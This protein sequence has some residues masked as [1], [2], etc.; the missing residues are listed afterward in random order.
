MFDSLFGFVVRLTVATILAL[1]PYAAAQGQ[2]S[3]AVVTTTLWNSPAAKATIE[4]PSQFRLSTDALKARAT[5]KQDLPGGYVLKVSTGE[6]FDA[7][8]LK[9]PFTYQY[10]EVVSAVDNTVIPANS[11]QFASRATAMAMRDTL[12]ALFPSNRFILVEHR[13][14]G[15]YGNTSIEYGVRSDQPCTTAMNAGLLA[16]KV[17]VYPTL[18]SIALQLEAYPYLSGPKGCDE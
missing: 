13:K 1:V 11:L 6:V 7:K 4:L 17:L 14:I 15:P 18:W 16:H 9:Q 2:T 8:G 5:D 10:T 3:Q 12:A